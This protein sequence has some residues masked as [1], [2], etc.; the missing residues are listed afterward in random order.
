MYLVSG[1]INYNSVVATFCHNV[2]RNLD[3]KV[4]NP[5]SAL[6]LVYIDDVI[7]R[8]IQLMDGSAHR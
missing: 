5:Q 3:I 8:L 7:E 1:A 6:T 2:A 4:K